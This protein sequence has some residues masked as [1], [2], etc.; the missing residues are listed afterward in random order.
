LASI[1]YADF[2]ITDSFHGTAFSIL[3]NK[4]FIVYGNKQR[5]NARLESLLGCF[6]LT[7]RYV[8]EHTTNYET[9]WKEAIDWQKVNHTLSVKRAEAFVFL[10]D[11]LNE[12]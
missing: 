5:G 6:D 3:F 8:D 4:P 11:N 1:Y 10:Q 9:L 2:V 7:N 12:R